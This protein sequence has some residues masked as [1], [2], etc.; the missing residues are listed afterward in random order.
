MMIGWLGLWN[1][2]ELP[3][4][5]SNHLAWMPAELTRPRS[6]SGKEFDIY[7]LQLMLRHRQGGLPMARYAA[8]HAGQVVTGHGAQPLPPPI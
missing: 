4:P 1:Y 8:G 7:L 5:G 3:D 6:L 2:S